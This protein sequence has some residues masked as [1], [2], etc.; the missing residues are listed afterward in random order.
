M[1]GV[2]DLVGQDLEA[3]DEGPQGSPL[4]DPAQEAVDGGEG[5]AVVGAR[6]EGRGDQQQ[7]GP[8]AEDGPADPRGDGLEVL[9]EAAVGQVELVDAG[10]AEDLRRRPRLPPAALAT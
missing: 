6:L 4:P 5:G 8:Q 2:V 1:E 7:L 10:D 3:L 9:L